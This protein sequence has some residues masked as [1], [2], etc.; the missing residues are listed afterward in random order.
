MNID[1][2]KGIIDFFRKMPKGS[3]K[4]TK[5]K[6]LFP[7]SMVVVGDTVSGSLKMVKVLNGVA[8]YVD[9]SYGDHT[10]YKDLSFICTSPVV[11]II[12][13]TKTKVTFK[14]KGGVYE[15]KKLKVSKK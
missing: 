2:Q 4:L 10:K 8:V 5:T 9:D 11:A 14:T 7:L 12:G 3:Y 13:N 6:S 1:D 15:L